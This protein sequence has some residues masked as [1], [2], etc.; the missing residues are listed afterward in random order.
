M[1]VDGGTERWYGYVYLTNVALRKA[2]ETVRI[3]LMVKQNIASML[4]IYGLIN[5]YSYVCNLYCKYR[6]RTYVATQVIK[7]TYG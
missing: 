5:I 3:R 1:E 6:Y 2:S 7:G 4:L